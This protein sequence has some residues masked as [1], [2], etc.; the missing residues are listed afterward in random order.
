M[1]LPLTP[2][3]LWS[4]INLYQL[5]IDANKFCLSNEY[6]FILKKLIKLLL[7]RLIGVHCSMVQRIS[8]SKSAWL[9]AW[10][11]TRDCLY[12]ALSVSIEYWALLM[13]WKAFLYILG[14]SCSIMHDSSSFI[15]CHLPSKLWVIDYIMDLTSFV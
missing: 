7:L 10:K 11:E 2:W 13:F 4:K 5:R 15:V 9:Q 1:V 6:K 8:D 12:C 14:L 3:C